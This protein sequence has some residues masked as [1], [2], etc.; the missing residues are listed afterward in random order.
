MSLRKTLQRLRHH[1]TPG[2][3]VP[4]RPPPRRRRPEVEALEDRTVPTCSL[5]P[6]TGLLTVTGTEG[7][8]VICLQRPDNDHLRVVVNRDV[9][10]F[11]LADV[12]EVR[13]DTLGGDDRVAL[14]VGGP[15]P[16]IARGTHVETGTGNDRVEV[17]ALAT[18]ATVTSQGPAVVT[19]GRAGSLAGV[20]GRLTVTGDLGLT[21]LR[22]NDSADTA[23]RTATL[24]FDPGNGV[25][26][27][28]GLAPTPGLVQY[29]QSALSDLTVTGGTVANTY[30]VQNT[31][32]RLTTT[33]NAGSG[34][35][36]VL[37][38][39]T[40]GPLHIHGG[41]RTALGGP[42][43]D[44]T[45]SITADDAVTLSGD[46]FGSE[47]EADGVGSLN[48]GNGA[49]KFKLV[50]C[51]TF[52]GP[53]NG[54]GGVNTLNYSDYIC[55]VVVVN[56]PLG[57]ATGV[58][59]GISAIQ[60]VIGANGGTPGSSYNVLLGDGGN[61]LIGGMGRPNLLAAGLSAGSTLK[62]GDSGD[63]F[64]R[65]S[66]NHDT[67]ADWQAYF[68]GI[69]GEWARA[70]LVG[71]AVQVRAEKVTHLR[72]DSSGG[73]N[74]PYYLAPGDVT[75]NGAVNTIIQGGGLDWIVV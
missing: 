47:V 67:D 29:D 54:G 14:N 48:G 45:W 74:P 66:T 71:T 20:Q 4:G 7:A 72:G 40:G 43:A 56:L 18:D 33:L 70:D 59:G 13:V 11:A 46:A 75:A 39:A 27:V 1:L 28:D 22:V 62:G 31:A 32:P 53:V 38:R 9:C 23:S 73:L 52:G 50:D 69:L 5:D 21:T 68:A 57:W 25:G 36:T 16:L 6:V 65:G 12:R 51:P 64:I 24:S 42:G 44:T 55:D 63:I 34:N 17:L 8:D 49:D 19:V 58:S 37:L 35:D 61:V 60:N 41:G 10:L 30:L 2:G 26:T 3:R 15:G